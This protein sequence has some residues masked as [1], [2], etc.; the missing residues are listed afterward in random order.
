MENLVE[1]STHI[2][3]NIRVMFQDEAGFGRINSPKACWCLD[4]I[5]PCVPCHRIY[6]YVYTYGAVSPKDGE[7]F[8]LI[9]PQANTACMNLFLDQLSKAFPNDYIFLIADNAVWH[10]PKSLV[11]PANMEIYSL[12]P[13]TP[14]LNPIEQIWDEVRE[15]VFKNKLFP[16]LNKVVDRL[17]DTLK[18]LWMN[19]SLVASI[20]QRQWF[21]IYIFI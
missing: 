20:T 3:N 6:E 14:E 13:Y 11:I 19:K 17:S 9:L 1:L 21:F 16:S 12:S 8:S 7:L 18:S 10:R 5:R 15:K 2:Q 4:D